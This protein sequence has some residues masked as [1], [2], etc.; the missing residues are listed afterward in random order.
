M[1]TIKDFRKRKDYLVCVDSDGCAMDTMDVKHIRCFGPCMVE[2]WSL[3][4]WSDEILSRWNEINLYTMTRGIN[5]FRGL[6]MALGEISQK[7]RPIEGLEDLNAWIASGAAPSNDA[8]EE[9]IRR[10]DSPMLKKALHWS[11]NVN[12]AINALPDSVKLPFPGVKEALTV[13]HE[14]ADVAIVS[15]ANPEAVLEEWEKYELLPCTDVICAQDVGSKAHCIEELLRKGY[16][17]DHALMCG[18]AAGDR[19]A[20]EHNGIFFYP[21]C[22]R[23]EKES[24]KEFKDTAFDRLLDGSYAG[25]YQQTLLEAFIKNLGG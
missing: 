5:R 8:L 7:Y 25:A 16:A 23:H 2:E 9:A 18:D 15:S 22:V 12:A 11:K 21:I 6:S 3:E 17:P 14:R 13:A 10:T 20:A 1:G 24:W 19:D 4:E